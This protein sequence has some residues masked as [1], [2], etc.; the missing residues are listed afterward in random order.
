MDGAP[1]AAVRA[2]LGLGSN[3]GDRA[4]RLAEAAA[5]LEGAGV[6]VVRRSRLYETPP[7]GKPDQ[8][9]FL[10]QVL[11]VETTLAPSALLARCQA[12]ERALGRLRAERWGPR[13]IDVDIL[14]YG[15]AVIRAP[16]LVVPHAELPRRAFVLVPLLELRPNLTLPDGRAAA[17]LLEGLPD[18]GAIVPWSTGARGGAAQV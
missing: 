5:K 10:N 13:V 3:V 1:R 17:D 15:D 18:R 16:G 4:S 11:E 2:Y 14:L 6:R 12:V 8:P 7:W 9:A